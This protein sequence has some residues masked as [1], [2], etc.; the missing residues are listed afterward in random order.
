VG[1]VILPDRLWQAMEQGRQVQ[2]HALTTT[3]VSNLMADYLSSENAV[4]AIC[5]HLPFLEGR[6]GKKWTGELE[7]WLRE[8]RAAD[9]TQVLLERYYDPLY[10]H[11]DKSRNWCSTLQ[12]ESPTLLADL[13]DLL[14]QPQEP[15]Q[16]RPRE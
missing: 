7:S 4:E 15:F 3:R 14:Q 11:G 16:L 1:D 8:G 2:L 10:A 9:V 5:A 6:I 13:F 12:V